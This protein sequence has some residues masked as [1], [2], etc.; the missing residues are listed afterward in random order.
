LQAVVCGSNR[1]VYYSWER[2]GEAVS[3]QND[4]LLPPHSYVKGDTVTVF[5]ESGG[6]KALA[7]TTIVNSPPKVLSVPFADPYIHRGV[8][9]VAEPQEMDVDGDPVTFRFLWKVNGS[10]VF[11]NDSPVLS[12]EKFHKGDHISLVVVPAD[13]E[14]E[15]VP[16]NGSD[17]TVPN[18]PPVFVS[19]PSLE[20]NARVYTYEVQ[21]EDPDGDK[22]TYSL[23]SAPT[24]MSI[25]AETGRINWELKPEYSGEHRIRIVAQDDEGMKASQEFTLSLSIPE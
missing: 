10:E 8:D 12:G 19:S 13:D 22:L 14:G 20:F 6:N 17:F 5:V 9:I 21:A 25:D 7:K 3:G 1:E 18:T 24:E 4:A 2:N 16:F 15:G 23:E 11:G